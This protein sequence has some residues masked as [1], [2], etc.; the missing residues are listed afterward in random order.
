MTGLY[1]VPQ[2]RCNFPAMFVRENLEMGEYLRKDR[3]IIEDIES[4][5]SRFPILPAK[6]KEMAGNLSGG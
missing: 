2:G 5:Y 1:Y 6:N 4:L 3:Q